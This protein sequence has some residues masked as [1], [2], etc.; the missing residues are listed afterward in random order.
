[1]NMNARN[2]I[3]GSR[4]EGRRTNDNVSE[5][6]MDSD[7]DVNVNV[8]VNTDVN[9]STNVNNSSKMNGNMNSNMNSNMNVNGNMSGN[10]NLQNMS[11]DMM[12][13]MLQIES[14]SS[15]VNSA[16]VISV[17]CTKTKTKTRKLRDLS[18]LDVIA[19]PRYI[20][21]DGSRNSYDGRNNN[22]SGNNNNDGRNN[23]D[24]N[25]NNNT[26]NNNNNNN[27]TR[28][29]ASRI[30]SRERTYIQRRNRALEEYS[31]PK[32]QVTAMNIDQKKTVFKDN[33]TLLQTIKV[34]LFTTVIHS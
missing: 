10:I 9:N 34:V 24:R 27:D 30:S 28:R 11:P 7:S 22:N 21:G 14:D 4:I 2:D 8:N 31:G 6:V 5:G 26:N 23:N 20:N 3:N 18:V 32:A 13:S 29:S 12:L 25:N 19:G 33:T 16:G 17:S 1:M 15:D